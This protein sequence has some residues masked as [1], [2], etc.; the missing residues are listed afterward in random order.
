MRIE[1]A[2][3]MHPARHIAGIERVVNP[4]IGLQN[5]FKLHDLVTGGH[6]EPGLTIETQPHRFGHRRLVNINPA[7]GIAANAVEQAGLIGGDGQ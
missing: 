5:I 2:G 6:G 7:F 1:T 3:D 4:L